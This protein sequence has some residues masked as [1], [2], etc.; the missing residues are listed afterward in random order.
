MIRSRKVNKSRE[1]VEHDEKYFDK[2]VGQYLSTVGLVIRK[3]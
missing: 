3:C 2:G 1:L